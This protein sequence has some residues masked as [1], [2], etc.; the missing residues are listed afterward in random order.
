MIYGTHNT[1]TYLKPRKW[2]MW[3]FN[4]TAKCQSITLYEQ[5]NKYNVRMFDMRVRFRNGRPILAHGLVEYDVVDAWDMDDFLSNYAEQHPNEEFYC[6]VTLE[7]TF[8]REN[9][10][11]DQIQKFKEFCYLL[12]INAPKN[13]H[14]VGGWQKL[15]FTKVYSF[16]TPQP[17]MY[18]NHASCSKYKIVQLWPWIY[19]KLHNKETHKK[20]TDKQ[21]LMMDFIQM[22][23]DKH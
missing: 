10:Y 6:R 22:G 7:N 20:G 1:M 16:N 15:D 18:G 17:D 13:L 3:L 11:W 9:T 8:M 2:W 4:W 12:E 5:A 14:Y 21:V 19:A 23:Y